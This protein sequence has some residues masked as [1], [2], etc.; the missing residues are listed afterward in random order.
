MEEWIEP[1]ESINDSKVFRIDLPLEEI[2]WLKMNLR[3]Q[4]EGREW[5]LT[6]H[7]RVEIVDEVRGDL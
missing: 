4:S 6:R 2:V 1:G 3:V 5:N 7:I